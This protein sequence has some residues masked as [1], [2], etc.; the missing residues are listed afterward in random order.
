MF[1]PKSQTSDYTSD[2]ANRKSPDLDE[3]IR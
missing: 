2:E 1:Q 3:S